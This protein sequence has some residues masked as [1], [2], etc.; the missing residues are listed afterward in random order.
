MKKNKLMIFGS[1]M[2][3]L[4][5]SFILCFSQTSIKGISITSTPDVVLSS[6]SSLWT[7][8]GKAVCTAAKQQKLPQIC[9]DGVG[10]AVITWVDE[11]D[12]ATADDIYAQRINSIGKIQ[13]T[14]NGEAICTAAGDQLSAQLCS[15]CAGGAIIT[16]I[17]DT[18]SDFNIYAQKINSSGGTEWTGNGT[19][20]CMAMFFQ[21][22]LQICSDGAGGAIIAWRD[23]RDDSGDIYVQRINSSGGVEWT[24]DGFAI[25]NIIGTQSNPQICYDGAGG[26]IITWQDKRDGPAVDDIYA[27]RINSSGD[28]YWTSNG[29]AICTA[30]N[31]QFTPKLCSDGAGGAII[32]WQDERDGS[33]VDDIYAQ[34]INSSGDIN[35]TGNG[36]AICTAENQQFTP[37]LCS[38]G[39]GGA[40]ITWEDERKVTNRDIYALRVNSSGDIKGTA[41]GTAICTADNGQWSPQLCSDGTGGAVITWEDERDGAANDDIYAQRINSIGGVEWIGNG[42]VICSADNQQAYPQICSNGVGDAIITWEDER[43]GGSKDDIYAQGFETK[44]EFPWYLLLLGHGREGIIE[45]LFSPLGL[46]MMASVGLAAI[47]SVVVYKNISSKHPKTKRLDNIKIE[48]E[49]NNLILK[50]NITKE[51]GKSSTE[52]TIIVANSHGDTQIKD[53]DLSFGMYAFKYETKKEV[54]DKGSEAMQNIEVK[55][56]GNTAVIKIDM[57]RQFGPSSMGKSKIVASSRGNR[58]IKDSGIYFGLNVYK[59]LK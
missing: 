6:K 22:E 52:K 12:G 16:W 10:G 29:I 40:V 34:R 37:Q 58:L 42:T 13:W 23:L 57:G 36:T 53:T 47:I 11:R 55:L 30:D 15:D 43:D 3:I 20:I 28:I 35:W 39:A 14:P 8:N 4:F 27:Q 59:K 17:H 54:R 7:A 19:A 31:Q 56:D 45:F 26:A 41:N 48:I 33:T 24:D 18:G 32:T 50:F 21:I 2:F 49:G 9:S 1:L 5:T 25:C 51:L 44:M 38:D 46:L